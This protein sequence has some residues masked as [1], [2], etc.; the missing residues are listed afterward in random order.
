MGIKKWIPVL[1]GIGA[2]VF[3]FFLWKALSSKERAHLEQK[4]QLK[5][6]DLRDDIKNDIE[7]RIMALLRMAKRWE[8]RG[9]PTREEWES[10]ASLYVKHYAGYQAIGWVDPSFKLRW[11]MP[12]GGDDD[13]H[14]FEDRKS[15]LLAARNSKEPRITRSILFPDGSKGFLVYVP[16]YT[17]GGLG[18]FIAGVFRSQDLLDSMLKEHELQG[19]SIAVYDGNEELYKGYDE[20]EDYGFADERAISLYGAEWYVRVWPTF[21]YLKEARSWLPDTVLFTGLVTSGLLTLMVWLGMMAE[22]RAENAE[23]INQ[24]L[25]REVFERKRA[26]EEAQLRAKEIER[27]NSVLEHEVK[28]RIKAEKAAE[29]QAA[30]LA[31]SNA[32]LEQ[33]AYVASHDLQ[34]PLRIVAGYVQLLARRYRGKLD[35]DADEFIDFA[36]DAATRMQ[37]L[38]NDLLT[39]SRVGRQKEFTTVDCKELLKHAVTSLKASIDESGA[40]VVWGRL[41][42]IYADPSQLDHLFM[43]LIGNAIKYRG[44]APPEINVSAQERDGEWVFCVRDNGIGIDTKH[45]ERIFV[46]FQRLHG[47]T[48]YPGTGIGLSICKKVVENHRGRIWVDSMAGKGSSFYFTIPKA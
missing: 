47:K 24:D 12:A 25:E 19:I 18:G 46:I 13:G 11:V 2:V 43:N 5:A 39:Y 16:I 20:S 33:F 29:R 41:P 23:Q 40:K 30:E 3:T 10:D 15:A 36:V 6:A 32:E 44:S 35:R 8:V 37:R 45:F 38:I 7:S 1:I 34:E 17:D 31:R 48:E 42:V 27:A 9:M 14:G 26:E 21:E 22:L 28:E 4:V